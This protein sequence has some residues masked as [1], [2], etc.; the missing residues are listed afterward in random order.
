MKIYQIGGAVRDKVIGITPVDTD[1]VVVGATVEEMEQLGFYSVGKSFPVFLHPQTKEEYALARKEIKTGLKHTDFKFDFNKTITL[2]EDVLR[3]DFT[4]N[5]LAYDEATGELIDFVGGK[6]DIDDKIIRHINAEHFVEDPLRVL[7]M[8]RFSAQLD[9]CIHPETMD[10]AKKMVADDMLH[11]LSKERVFKEIEKALATKHF[12]KFILSMKESGALKKI[13]PE[14]DALFFVPE[15]EKYHPE[16]NTGL[17]TILSIQKAEE[18]TPEIKFAV[19]L[20]D[21]GKGLTPKSILPSHTGHEQRGINLVK[22]I[23]NRLRVPKRYK[24]M[25]LLGCENHMLLRDIPQ[26]ALADIYDFVD[27]VTTHFKHQKT[28]TDLFSICQ[29]DLNGRAL[30]LS[31]TEFINFETAKK[32]CLDLFNQMQKIKR[33]FMPEICKTKVG[34]EVAKG[35]K[36]QALCLLKISN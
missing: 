33:E 5:A 20:H 19:L 10:L 11:H 35:L 28:L 30:P 7:R 32:I 15:K 25:A 13:L 21:V 23:C 27:K 17:H 18:F 34:C 24:K 14:V 26:M 31:Q 22:E 8:C 3:R 1:Y 2:K 12:D 4:M 29:S 9:F 16:K 36:E 6:K